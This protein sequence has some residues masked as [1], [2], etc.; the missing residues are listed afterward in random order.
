MVELRDTIKMSFR[1]KGDISINEFAKLFGGGGHKNAAGATVPK[2]SLN[3]LEE[4]IVKRYKVFRSKH[5]IIS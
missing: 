5:K 4:D 1:S 3:E 2:I